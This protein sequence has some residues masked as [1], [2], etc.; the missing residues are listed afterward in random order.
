MMLQND[1]LKFLVFAHHLS[2]LQACTEAVIESKVCYHLSTKYFL[3][4]VCGGVVSVLFL[5]LLA[6]YGSSQARDCI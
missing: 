3:K 6:A 4:S 2:M 5:A 1:S